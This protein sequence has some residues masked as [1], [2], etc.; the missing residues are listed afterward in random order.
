[1]KFSQRIGKE[2]IENDIQVDVVSE[3]LRVGIWNVFYRFLIKD[4]WALPHATYYDEYLD[5]IW[6][7]F[8]KKPLDERSEYRVLV[9]QMKKWIISCEWNQ[10]FDFIEFMISILPPAVVPPFILSNNKVLMQERSA[11]R[12]IDRMIMPL[13]DATE[14]SE[15]KEAFRNVSKR[16]RLSDVQNHL[17]A[18][19]A[20]LGQRT[21][22]N[23]ELAVFEVHNAVNMLAEYVVGEE[24]A[25][26]EQLLD[27]VAKSIE[28]SDSFIKGAIELFGKN[29]LNMFEGMNREII[30]PEAKFAV[31][32]GSAFINYILSLYS[33]K[34][35]A[36]SNELDDHKLLTD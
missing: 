17:A 35:L 32:S 26:I 10:V 15:V 12:I 13:T 8:L 1:M 36:D 11:Y 19:L 24:E 20:Q 16:G 23:Y 22:S 21:G 28:L 33:G 29:N 4:S 27:E 31:V 25:T 5:D 3:D 18:A 2:P 6:E 34:Q 30:L 7:Y 9:A 14:M